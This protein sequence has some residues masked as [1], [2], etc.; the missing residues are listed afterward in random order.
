MPPLILHEL[1]QYECLLKAAERYASSDSTAHE[2]FLYL[3]HATDMLLEEIN[4]AFARHKISNRRFIVMILLNRVLGESCTLAT[5][6]RKSGVTPATM[7]GII[8]TLEKEGLAERKEDTRDR[9]FIPVS[10]TDK[11]RSKLIA[12][13]PDCFQCISKIMSPLN[14][15]ECQE[16]VRLLQKLQR[17][18]SPPSSEQHIKYSTI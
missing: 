5:L 9:R 1:P 14:R 18:G 2:A 4:K 3:Q 10:L 11:G 17:L 12:M 15:R 6:A 7:T 16:L 8:D 13:L